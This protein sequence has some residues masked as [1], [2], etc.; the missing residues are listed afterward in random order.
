MDTTESLTS[1]QSRGSA[2]FWVLAALAVGLV[3]VSA[4]SFWIDE[5]CT[6][7]KATQTTLRLWWEVNRADR[8]SDLQMPLYMLFA[9]GWAQVFGASEVALRGANLPWF[10]LGLVA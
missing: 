5:A 2:W 3:A 1:A 9:W 8:G 6:A 7:W 10:W 4:Q